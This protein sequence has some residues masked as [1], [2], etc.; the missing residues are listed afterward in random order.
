M[1]SREFLDPEICAKERSFLKNTEAQ[2]VNQ[3][4]KFTELISYFKKHFEY[5]FSKFKDRKDAIKWRISALRG[6]TDYKQNNLLATTAIIEVYEEVEQCYRL[7]LDQ[8]SRE[9]YLID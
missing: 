6:W 8:I 2:I 1:L 4:M 3:E 7:E 5:E 9:H